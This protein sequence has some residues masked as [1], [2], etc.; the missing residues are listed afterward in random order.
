M[1]N[2][3]FILGAGR[4]GTTLIY[5]MLVM[6][7]PLISGSLRESQFFYTQ[8]KRPY[9]LENCLDYEYYQDFLNEQE[10]RDIHS[11]SGDHIAFLRNMMAYT[12]ERDG[13]AYFVEKSP[14]NT[15]WYK[16]II[17]NF[18]QP[19]ILFVQRKAHS[20]IHSVV[21]TDYIHLLSDRLPGKL[22]HNTMLKYWSACL[23]YYRFHRLTPRILKYPKVIKVSYD[24]V[25]RQETD[26]KALVE[27]K[28]DIRL[29]PLFVT[30]PN[31]AE[32]QQSAHVLDPSR[33]EGYKKKMPV[34]AQK[35]ADTIFY[36][37]GTGQQI[38]SWLIRNL[39]FEPWIFVRWLSGR[40]H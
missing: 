30:S 14:N 15:F 28:L 31:S 4:S 1:S 27:S 16:E 23:S 37:E 18:E 2:R 5:G 10:I 38:K 39:L 12:L 9:T 33:L 34:K 35:L 24:A 25:V 13:K 7:Q 26:L 40:R 8:Y 22:K 29:D 3:I 11:R 19:W 36:P 6:N 21:V 17:E 32:S 20:S